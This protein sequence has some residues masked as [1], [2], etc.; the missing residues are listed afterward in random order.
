MGEPVLLVPG[1][2]S[3][4]TSWLSLHRLLVEKHPVTIP[5]GHQSAET[6]A[7]MGARILAQS[8][9]RFHLVG[10]SMGGYIA[11]ELLRQKPESLISL[12]L[13][14]TTA[15]PEPKDALGRRQEA[16]AVARSLGMRAYQSQNLA[17]CVHDPDA[18]A[19]DLFEAI[20]QSSA[21]L[22]LAAFEAQTRA[23]I[24]RPDSLAD[25]AT[26][27]CPV[28]VVAGENDPVMPMAHARQMHETAQGSRLTVIK[29]CGHCPPLE[30]PDRVNDI[31]TDWFADVETSVRA[32]LAV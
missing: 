24:G 20:V 17:N 10:W 11:F 30:H 26:C 4:G 9:P 27:P 25:L 13:M 5:R 21:N 8:P 19:P 23:I 14:A 32:P 31:L 1:L 16:L 22:G 18:L 12:T 2:Q 7:E 15:Q 6:I 29:D 3:D 28:L